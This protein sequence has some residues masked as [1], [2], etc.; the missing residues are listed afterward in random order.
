MKP[1][2]VC[3]GLLQAISVLSPGDAPVSKAGGLLFSWHWC[4]W[5]PMEKTA[6]S[7]T[8][9]R[10]GKG[11]LLWGGHTAAVS[12]PTKHSNRSAQDCAAQKSEC[13]SSEGRLKLVLSRN[14]S[15]ASVFRI[16]R[17]SDRRWSQG[18]FLSGNQGEGQG[19]YFK[20][21]EKHW[22]VLSYEKEKDYRKSQSSQRAP[23][24]VSCT[25][26]CW[27]LKRC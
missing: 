2:F 9:K 20:C 13:R 15:K 24:R 27:G 18:H 22:R 1:C 16:Y 8:W 7:V 26:E 19:L 17:E 21:R 11:T 4:V 5:S 3:K 23:V 6:G 12:E 25:V 10:L 14:S